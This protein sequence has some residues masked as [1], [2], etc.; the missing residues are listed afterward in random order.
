MALTDEKKRSK[1]KSKWFWPIS[2][3]LVIILYLGGEFT[4]EIYQKQERTRSLYRHAFRLYEEQ[5]AIYIKENYAG[6]S[7]IS[8]SPILI[9]PGS[10]GGR[11]VSV[12]PIVHDKQGNRGLLRGVHGT[13]GII[14][15]LSIDSDG[16]DMIYFAIPGEDREVEVSQYKKLPKELRL[17]EDNYIDRE[18]ETLLAE[19][20][21]DGVSKNSSGS[22]EAE[23]EYNLKIEKG[24]R[25]TWR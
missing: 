21:I 6:V 4:Y 22:P 9:G 23:I 14:T 3:I 25:R 2:I 1:V 17:K 7:K 13:G 11:S 5:V 15:T 24:D 10:M 20:I 18:V 16:N 19:K 8:F 12:V